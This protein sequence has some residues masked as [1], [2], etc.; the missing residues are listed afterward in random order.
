MSLTNPKK[1]IIDLLKDATNGVK[2]YDDTPTL[3]PG[4]V[5]AAWYDKDIFA[6][7]GWQITVGPSL[8]SSARV[9][10]LG[11]LH[12]DYDDV[13]SVSIWVLEKR[14]VNYTPERLR[15]DLIH[16]VDRALYR[17]INDPIS[18]IDHVN[19][20]GWLDRDEPE[21]EILRSDLTV[22]VEYRK[23]KPN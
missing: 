17:V 11:A 19:L 2:V 9:M 5:S 18:G 3:V 8:G 21:N 12:K 22:V 4:V 14:G 10:D 23:S 13:L 1:L 16:E 7:V 6:T 15:F 20:S